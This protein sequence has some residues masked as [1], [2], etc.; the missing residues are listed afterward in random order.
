MDLRLTGIGKRRALYPDIKPYF[1][2]VM[3][4]GNGHSI[5]VEQCGNPEGIPV[6]VLHGGPGGGCSAGMRQIFNPR[7]FRVVLFDQRGCGRSRPAGCV[8]ANTTWHLVS[9]MEFIRSRLE[10]DR[11]IVFGGSWGAALG[12]IYAQ[13]HPDRVMHLVLRGIFLMTRPELD[14]FYRGGVAAFW[15]DAWERFRNVIPGEEQDDLVSAYHRRL[16]SGDPDIEE[17]HGMAWLIWESQLSTIERIDL[18]N[19]APR[20]YGR[21]FSRIETHYFVNSGFLEDPDHII[22]N[23]GKMGNLPGT[24]VQG[25]FDLVCPPVNAHRLRKC[26]PDCD[27]R[28][29]RAGHAMTEPEITRELVSVLDELEFN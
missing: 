26:W 5:H 14:W 13:N 22:N 23:M 28:I 2:Q 25:R 10:I 7:K 6:V 8:D 9:D 29:V 18:L 3:E 1:Q 11:W 21:I 27:L 4:V 20:R 17:M 15:P 16:F 12:L 19:E 24:I